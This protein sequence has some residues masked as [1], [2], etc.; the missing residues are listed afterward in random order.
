M[1]LMV[2]VAWWSGSAQATPGAGPEVSASRGRRDGVTVLWSRVV[3]AT[4]DPTI[5]AVALGVQE[6]AE[7]AAAGFATPGRVDRRPAPERVCPREGCRSVSVSVWIGHQGGGC[8]A[9]AVIGPPGPTPQ[10]LVPLAG[11][12][13]L[14]GPEIP[15]R[16]RPED[17]VVVREFVPCAGLRTALDLT[18]LT[19]ALGEAGA[20][21]PAP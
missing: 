13:D 11:A 19:R 16:E 9:V 6:A 12:V 3:P 21:S 17:H 5:T 4:E 20:A 14:A 10:R 15:Y 2:A 7:S 1:W 8:A 18:A